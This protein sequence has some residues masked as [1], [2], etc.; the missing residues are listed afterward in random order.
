MRGSL[1]GKTQVKI[2]VCFGVGG[3]EGN[4]REKTRKI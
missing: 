4:F 3:G 2:G 1:G